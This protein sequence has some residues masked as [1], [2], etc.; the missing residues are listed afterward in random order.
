M[1]IDVESLS[2][3]LAENP[4][5]SDYD[6]WRAMKDLNNEISVVAGGE[7]PLPI[8]LLYWREIVRRAR[9]KRG[10]AGLSAQD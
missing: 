1:K 8:D 5:F 10:A 2:D 6:F 3:E 4:Y 7:G 9:L